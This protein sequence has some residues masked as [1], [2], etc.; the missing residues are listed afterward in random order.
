MCVIGPHAVACVYNIHTVYMC[1]VGDIAVVCQVAVFFVL[2][3]TAKNRWASTTIYILTYC[4][5]ATQNSE[6]MRSRT[7]NYTE[8]KSLK[9]GIL[10]RSGQKNRTHNTAKN[11]KREVASKFLVSHETFLTPAFDM[12]L[13]IDFSRQVLQVHYYCLCIPDWNGMG[14]VRG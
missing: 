7:Q 4:I 8:Q 13:K 9:T 2:L 3:L 14:I 6:K 10:F 5:L 12:T 1:V 11:N